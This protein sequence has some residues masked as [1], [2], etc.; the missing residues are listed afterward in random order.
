MQEKW[1]RQYDNSCTTTTNTGIAD[2]CN[3]THD[4]RSGIPRFKI[5][6]SV[7]ISNGCKPH[8]LWNVF[9]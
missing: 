1:W 9:G 6:M 8:I 2:N 3:T 5:P 4:P 7:D